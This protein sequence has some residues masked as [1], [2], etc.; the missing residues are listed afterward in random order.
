VFNVPE[1]ERASNDG[2][3]LTIE[4]ADPKFDLH[5]TRA[6]LEGLHPAGVS[7]IAA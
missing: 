7:D 3:F 1:F 2:L 5:A 4:T 6:F